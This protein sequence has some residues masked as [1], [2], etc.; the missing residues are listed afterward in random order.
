M[1]I[2]H[3]VSVVAAASA[4]AAVEFRFAN[5]CG[6]TINLHGGG[7]KFICDIEPGVQVGNNCGVSLDDHG[8]FKHS[9]SNEANCTY[10][11]C[12]VRMADVPVNVYNIPPGPGWCSSFE[13]CKAFTRRSGYNIPVL[14]VPT[15][16]E[17][18]A[19]CKQLRV[20]RPDASDAYL[21]PA[22][23]NKTHDCPMDEVFDVIFCP[24]H[25][26]SPINPPAPSDSPVTQAPSTPA[27]IVTSQP[28]TP[29][30]VPV[31]T[32]P[33]VST[34]HAP[35]YSTS[36]PVSP[37]S[38]NDGYIKAWSQCDGKG[39]TGSS[40]C[41]EGHSCVAVNEWFSQCVPDSPK[42]GQLGTWTQCGGTGVDGKASC[43]PGD[44]CVKVNDYFFQ[45][46]PK[47]KH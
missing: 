11:F 22:D 26:A 37:P 43:R 15:K 31:P 46:Q 19:N 5:K 27:I 32:E 7:S 2:A 23:N 10:R 8:L 21:F 41:G 29:S 9:P 34:S 45:C 40:I 6:F 17:G 20:T 33:L 39:Y 13:D 38:N 42:F 3:L 12:V 47:D 14:V 36:P 28:A 25:N 4:V 1:F 24:D 18:Q 16:H 30:V 35:D 44:K